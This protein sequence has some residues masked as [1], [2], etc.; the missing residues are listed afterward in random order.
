M[1][2]EGEYISWVEHIE[3]FCNTSGADGIIDTMCEV[4]KWTKRSQKRVT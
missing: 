2:N 4:V 3:D 1:L